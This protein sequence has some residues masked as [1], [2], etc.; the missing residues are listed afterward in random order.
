M[1][2]SNKSDY[3]KVKEA[4]KKTLKEANKKTFEDNKKLLLPSKEIV[5]NIRTKQI[6]EMIKLICK[7]AELINEKG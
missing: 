2:R 4:N 5:Q 6:P 1:K 3:L 7:E